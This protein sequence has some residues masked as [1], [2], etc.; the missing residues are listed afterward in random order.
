MRVPRNTQAPL[1]FPGTL[2]TAGHWDQSKAAIIITLAMI[3]DRFQE[4]YNDCATVTKK[5]LLP[6]CKFAQLWSFQSR[7]PPRIPSAL[8]MMVT[9]GGSL[10]F[11]FL[12]FP[13]PM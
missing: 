9:F 10:K 4:H 13:P 5:S 7:T 12:V 8:E 6:S 1:R 2:S 3:V 11:S